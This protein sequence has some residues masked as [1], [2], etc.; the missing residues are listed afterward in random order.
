ME[1]TTDA[2]QIFGGY[3]YTKRVPRGEAHARRQ[4]A[5]DLRGH[6]ADPAR[7][8]RAQPHLRPCSAAD[9][10]AGLGYGTELAATV[11]DQ[12][13]YPNGGTGNT[14]LALGFKSAVR[15]FS[16]EAPAWQLQLTFGAMAVTSLN[17][18]SVGGWIY[19]LQSFRLPA[20]RTRLAVGVSYA[21]EQLYGPGV[22]EFSL[23]ASVEQPLPIPGVRGLSFVAEW[24]SGQHELSNLIFGLTWHPNPTWIFVLGWKIPTRYNTV[25]VNDMAAVV[26]VGF[27]LPPFG[28]RRPEDRS[29]FDDDHDDDDHAV[30]P[31]PHPR[32]PPSSRSAR[33]P[34]QRE[35]H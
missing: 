25:D 7:G 8:H 10:C 2:V 9:A 12:G 15:L 30:G 33:D 17:D 26:E 6:L 27:F 20:L 34:G 24:F 29:V 23:I 14:S 28:G 22:R 3:G 21:T 19:A 16:R 5:A 35:P 1:V 18:G 31:T 32:A 13:V 4:A 11:F